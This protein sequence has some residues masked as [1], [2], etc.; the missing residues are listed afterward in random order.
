MEGADPNDNYLPRLLP[1]EEVKD[2]TESEHLPG[3]YVFEKND[4]CNIAEAQD[5]HQLCCTAWTSVLYN[6]IR[7]RRIRNPEHTCKSLR[8]MSLFLEHGADV[9]A[10]SHAEPGWKSSAEISIRFRDMPLEIQ[11]EGS[12]QMNARAMLDTLFASGVRDE[13]MSL[14]DYWEERTLYHDLIEKTEVLEA[15]PASVLY[16]ARYF[17]NT[18]GAGFK[19]KLCIGQLV[20]TTTAAV[21][22]GSNPFEKFNLDESSQK[23][24][25]S[26]APFHFAWNFVGSEP[27]KVV[28]KANKDQGGPGNFHTLRRAEED[29]ARV[30]NSFILRGCVHSGSLALGNVLPYALLGVKKAFSTGSLIIDPDSLALAF[31]DAKADALKL[32]SKIISLIGKANNIPQ[33]INYKVSQVEIDPDEG[34]VAHFMVSGEAESAIVSRNMTPGNSGQQP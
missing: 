22:W 33:L 12:V 1:D 32:V 31:E 10:L 13:D 24:D 34:P 3:N 2:I 23:S 7:W 19:H 27:G 26:K 6:I 5:P 9:N 15:R 29:D 4:D 11:I 28:K 17:V 8:L 30:E 21:C 14:Q 16:G 18:Y 20:P 25:Q